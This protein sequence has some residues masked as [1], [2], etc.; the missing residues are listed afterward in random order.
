MGIWFFLL[1]MSGRSSVCQQRLLDFDFCDCH[2]LEFSPLLHILYLYTYMLLRSFHCWKR[3]YACSSLSV[4]N[5]LIILQAFFLQIIIIT[6]MIHKIHKT[7]R[8]HQFQPFTSKMPLP[9]CFSSVFPRYYDYD[10][11]MM[12]NE[13]IFYANA[14]SF[15]P[16][17]FHYTTTTP[18]F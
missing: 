13:M 7:Q 6:I 11:A 8:L 10:D 5:L 18:K 3:N 16:T 4:Y 9:S 12:G 17:H 15:H 1:G 14:P 2:T